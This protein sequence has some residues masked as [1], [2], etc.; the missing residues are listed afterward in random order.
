MGKKVHCKPQI[1]F[2]IYLKQ[3]KKAYM[4]TKLQRQ[5]LVETKQT[6]IDLGIRFMFSVFK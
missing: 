3:T 4:E 6:H 5:E 2:Q 1:T